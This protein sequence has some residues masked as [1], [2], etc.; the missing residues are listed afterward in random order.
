[1]FCF[2][3]ISRNKYNFYDLTISICCFKFFVIEAVENCSSQLFSIAENLFNF[4]GSQFYSQNFKIIILIAF[5][6]FKIFEPLNIKNLT[7]IPSQ[8]LSDEKTFPYLKVTWNFSPSLAIH[9]SQL[10]LMSF[11]FLN[12]MNMRFMQFSH[13]NF[14]T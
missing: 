13:W 14:S 12:M 7:Q 9:V 5:L 1:M 11:Q 6:T 3:Q 10:I 8:T 4:R 2:D